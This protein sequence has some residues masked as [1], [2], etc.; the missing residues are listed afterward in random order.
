MGIIKNFDKS[1]FAYI[2][3]SV[4]NIMHGNYNI[5]DVV[6]LKLYSMSTE[7]YKGFMNGVDLNKKR[8]L[9]VGSSGDQVFEYALRGSTDITLMD[10]NPLTP[11]F[12]ELKYAAIKALSRQDFI[13]FF[14]SGNT[15]FMQKEIYDNISSKIVSDTAK[16]FWDNIFL[17]D[18]N[19]VS[20][21]FHF[22]MVTK[23]EYLANDNNY[24]K[25]RELID[26]VSVKFHCA[27]LNDFYKYCD[28][29]YDL[30][31]LSNII[32]YFR[33]T[34]QDRKDFNNAVKNLYLN[35]SVDGMLKLSY[36]HVNAEPTFEFMGK[37]VR[38]IFYDNSELSILVWD[39]DLERYKATHPGYYNGVFCNW[40]EFATFKDDLLYKHA[41]WVSRIGFSSPAAL[42]AKTYLFST[43]IGDGFLQGVDLTGKRILTVGSSGDQVIEY[44][45]RGSTDITLMDANVITPFFCE[46]KFAALKALNRTEFMKFF[47]VG[48]SYDAIEDNS[49]FMNL[50]IYM[51]KIRPLIENEKVKKYWDYILKKSKSYVLKQFHFN[52]GSSLGFP[53]YLNSDDNYE[54]AREALNLIKVKFHFADIIDFSKYADGEY[55][56]IDLSN[57]YRYFEGNEQKYWDSIDLLY[58][59]LTSNGILKIE[60]GE[61]GE[62]K[63]DFM[64]KSTEEIPYG[65]SNFVLVVWYNDL[66]KYRQRKALNMLGQVVSD[67]TTGKGGRK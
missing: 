58:P 45:L 47:K 35:L 54:K 37:P 10:A 22:S 24:F 28:G 40:D 19:L 46:L 9:T 6:K 11:Y 5:S 44:A 36:G 61:K 32:H 52:S 4:Y 55:D 50:E 30:I 8:I 49:D 21:L 65:D 1:N 39:N 53:N 7:M 56:M 33:D 2:V 17:L 16:K 31:D 48:E 12:V 34:G 13:N 38:R 20:K 43:E 23:P 51:K 18:H 63:Y 57:I 41:D 67:S 62:Q 3:S 64:G 15:S 60:Y 59:Y 14:S 29:E 27:E 66:E 26:N 42:I 25:T